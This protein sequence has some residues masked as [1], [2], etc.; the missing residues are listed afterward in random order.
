[1][2]VEKLSVSF[3]AELAQAV[4]AS[5]EREG[6]SVSAW[7]ARSAREQ[8]RLEALADAMSAWEKR[9][10]ALTDAEIAEADHALQKAAARG[11][12]R[13]VA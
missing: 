6:T 11:R 2:A 5:A 7:L 3:D 1:M 9:F 4:R 13:R 10:G 8:L 12:R